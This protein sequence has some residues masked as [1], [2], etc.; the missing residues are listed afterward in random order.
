VWIFQH[1][2]HQ[3]RTEIRSELR[4]WQKRFHA[5]VERVGN[6]LRNFST[7]IARAKLCKV[8]FDVLHSLEFDHE[9]CFSSSKL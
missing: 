2:D 3:L 7:Q 4:L 9:N 5:I 8:S 6:F 1:F